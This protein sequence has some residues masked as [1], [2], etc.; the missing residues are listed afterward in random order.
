MRSDHRHLTAYQISCEV[1]QSVVLILRP[2]ILDRHILALDVTG[3][4]NASPECGQI[5]CTI[6]KRRAAEKPDY[7]WRSLLRAR[8]ERPR[9]CA[10][11]QRKELA[12]P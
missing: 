10:A 9:R 3:F 12:S 5:P 6:S 7:R 1:G 11:E 2:A 4:T 8:R